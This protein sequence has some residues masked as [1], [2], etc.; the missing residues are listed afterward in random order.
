MRRSK[1]CFHIYHY[2]CSEAHTAALPDVAAIDVKDAF[3][4]VPQEEPVIAGLPADCVGTGK[5]VFL[6]CVPG[7]RDGVQRGSI[8]ICVVSQVGD[9]A[10]ILRREPCDHGA[11]EGPMLMAYAC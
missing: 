8:I 6:K 10:H 11:P 9:A 2:K 3:L 4:E 1:A 5:Y 7:Q